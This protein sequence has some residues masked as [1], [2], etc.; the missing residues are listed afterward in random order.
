MKES[1]SPG[2]ASGLTSWT[3]QYPFRPK[4]Q[5]MKGGGFAALAPLQHLLW[6]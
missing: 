1:F 6:L 2:A 3:C 4:E 5:G